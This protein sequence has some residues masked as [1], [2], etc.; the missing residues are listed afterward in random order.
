MV[1]RQWDDKEAMEKSLKDLCIELSPEERKEITEITKKIFTHL[2]N[3]FEIQKNI[4]GENG[5]NTILYGC[6]KQE[7]DKAEELLSYY[8]SMIDKKRSER[9]KELYQKLEKGVP[10]TQEEYASIWEEAVDMEKEEKRLK[11]IERKYNEIKDEY[12]NQCAKYYELY[13][14]YMCEAKKTSQF[15]ERGDIDVKNL[16]VLKWL[17]DFCDIKNSFSNDKVN[18]ERDEIVYLGMNERFQFIEK[19]LNDFRMA[20]Q[21]LTIAM[22]FKKPEKAPE[23]KVGNQAVDVEAV[24]RAQEIKQFTIWLFDERLEN[25]KGLTFKELEA[26]QIEEIP[27]DP[28]DWGAEEALIAKKIEEAQRKDVE[29]DKLLVDFEVI[30]SRS[31]PAEIEALKE[32]EAAQS[33]TWGQWAASFLARCPN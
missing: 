19:A 2:N 6:M 18:L 23:K 12:E 14:E 21:A 5:N 11:E 17:K 25:D 29:A 1:T 4:S 7:L 13:K 32:M 28:R 16:K 22:L 15:Q 26:D 31:D 33:L 27:D 9:D 10:L 8:S 30:D 20:V 3:Y 24:L